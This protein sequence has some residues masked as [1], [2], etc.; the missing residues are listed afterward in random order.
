[1]E[2]EP[3]ALCLRPLGRLREKHHLVPRSHGGR[4]TVTLHPICH[5]KIHD[6]LSEREMAQ[7]Y[8][9]PEALRRHPEIGKFLRWLRDKPADFHKVTRRSRDGARR[10][11]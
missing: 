10:R 11:R 9:S 1:M 2:A 5:R 7:A 8:A 6:A 3:C 4:E